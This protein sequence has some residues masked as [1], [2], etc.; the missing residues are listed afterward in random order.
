[1]LQPKEI[2]LSNVHLANIWHCMSV[3][4]KFSKKHE[5]RATMSILIGC[6]VEHVTSTVRSMDRTLSLRDMWSRRFYAALIFACV[7]F[8]EDLSKWHSITR[9]RLVRT[10]RND[11]YDTKWGTYLPSQRF[12]VDQSPLPFV[13]DVKRTYEQMNY[14]HSEKVWIAQPGSGLDKRQCTLQIMT[15]A[16][17]E[18]PRLFSRQR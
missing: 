15:L 14:K 10:G 5:K 1:M 18:Q 3:C 9:E 8:R 13:F 6:G 12:N 4:S 17:G 2:F 7:A 16:E 11:K